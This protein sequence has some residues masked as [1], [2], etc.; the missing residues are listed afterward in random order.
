M[1]STLFER[2]DVQEV[3]VKYMTEAVKKMVKS[4]EFRKLVDAKPAKSNTKSSVAKSNTKASVAKSNT[5]TD[6]KKKKLDTYDGSGAMIVLNITTKSHG[7]VGDFKEEYKKFK[8][9]YLGAKNA[10]TLGV[11]TLYKLSTTIGIPSVWCFTKKG[12]DSVEKAL[13]E[14][15]IEYTI[16]NADDI[17]NSGWDDA[18]DL[19][20][21]HTTLKPAKKAKAGTSKTVQKKNN[22]VESASESEDDEPK[23]KTKAKAKSNTSKTVQKNTKG[24]NDAKGKTNTKSKVES[25]DD[26]SGSESE[27]DKPKSKKKG[28]PVDFDDDDDDDVK[29]R[30][31]NKKNAAN[32]DSESNVARS[33]TIAKKVI[34]KTG[35]DLTKNKFGNMEDKSAE[36]PIVWYNIPTEK[37]SM[38][39]AVGLQDG[40]SVEKGL[41]SLMA[42]T[43]DAIEECKN[44]KQ[45]YLTKDMLKTIKSRDKEL[46]DKLKAVMS[47]VVVESDDEGES[48]IDDGADNKS[49]S[50]SDSDDDSE[51]I[52]VDDNDVE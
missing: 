6:I 21:E 30:T 41:D 47:R 15:D 28:T 45:Q 24:K 2:D 37:G 14:E 50:D 25:E 5:K 51:E 23:T 4:A 7:L 12:L 11:S 29:T 46:H 52:E 43:D 42:L 33:K 39:V 10:K 3:L 22:K 13:R 26:E 9:T 16:K 38:G 8:E 49:K 18:E 27:D 44:K 32:S 19:T 35:V 40:D 48:T 1:D 36:Y 17:L 34:P 20:S 31:L